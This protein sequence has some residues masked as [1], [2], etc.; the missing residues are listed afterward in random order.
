MEV[1][2]M[3][4]FFDLQMF[5]EEAVAET[6]AETPETHTDNEPGAT[7]TEAK[8]TDDDV[9]K[10]LDRKFAEWQKKQ[11][12]KVSEAERLSKMTAEEKAAE[13]M[14]ALEDKLRGYE[15]AAARTE[16]TKQA[17]A[18]LSDKNI[19]VDDALL[20]N[21][22]AED[23]ESTKASVESF[24]TLFNAAVE[25]AVK[26]KVKGDTPKTGTTSGMTKEQILAIPN[27]AE[28]QRMMKE[29][30]DLF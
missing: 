25:K 26:E 7:K 22:I 15:V 17:R 1:I 16:M 23:A 12:K 2:Q 21:L 24:V 28:R 6:A 18:I 30:K 19:H 13:R 11:E 27:R 29:H 10:I 14:K 4:K 9:N 5:A 8:Y 20:A 3:K